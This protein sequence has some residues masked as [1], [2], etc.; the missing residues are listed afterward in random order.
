MSNWWDAQV[1][2]FAYIQKDLSETNATNGCAACYLHLVD[3]TYSI[4]YNIDK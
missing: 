3:L 4:N 2:H 1:S